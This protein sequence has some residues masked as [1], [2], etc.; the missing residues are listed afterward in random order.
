MAE[1]LRVVGETAAKGFR[2]GSY[3]SQKFSDLAKS[4]E[5]PEETRTPDEI[6]ANIRDK[7]SKI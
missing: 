1:C 7:I 6:I 4:E 2:G 3:V 5:K